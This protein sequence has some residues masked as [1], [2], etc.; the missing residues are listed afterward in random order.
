MPSNHAAGRRRVD[1]WRELSLLAIVLAGAALIP[2]VFVSDATD[3]LRL[4]KTLL[5]RA[6]AILLVSVVLAALIFGDSLRVKWRDPWLLLP[7]GAFLIFLLVTITSTKPV[8]SIDALGTAAASLVVFLCTMLAAARRTWALVVIPLASAVLNAALVIVEESRLWMPFGVRPDIPHHLQCTALIGNPNEVGAFL[9]AAALVCVAAIAAGTHAS[10]RLGIVIAAVLIAGLIASRTL[11]AMAA[12]A[13]AAIAVLI[14]DSW[15]NAFR[16]AA[17]GV[18]I[19]V[20]VIAF[21][22]PLRQRAANMIRWLKAGDYNMLLTDRLTPF[23][24][25]WSMF[26]DHPLTGVGPDAFAWQYY[27]YKLQ[28]EMRHPL[29]RRAYNRGVN[30]GEVHNDHLQ[31]L[32]EGGL[33]GYGAFAALLGALGSIS[34]TIPKDAADPFQRFARHLAFPLAAFWVV[35]S[36]AQFPLETTVVR[37]LLMHFAALCAAWRNG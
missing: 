33:A 15:K 35:L 9:A 7:F 16:V 31:V 4:P 5:L 23:A 20:L 11:T 10:R 1:R 13:A 30:Y 34:F 19:A 17:A 3:G 26:A 28:A 21:V 29:L 2:L 37:A 8:L 27:D 6:E 22:G 14:L 36:L 24:S 12:I 32:A 18:A 25:A